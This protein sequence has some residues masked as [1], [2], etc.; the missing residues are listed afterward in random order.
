MKNK[1]QL[2]LLIVWCCSVKISTAQ[3]S[4]QLDINNINA[5]INTKGFLFNSP[6]AYLHG[7]EA[8]KIRPKNMSCIDNSMCNFSVS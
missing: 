7:F 1:I 4:Q 3:T 8:T 5:R 6:G 2:L